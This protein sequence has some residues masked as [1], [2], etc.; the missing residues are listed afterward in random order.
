MKIALFSLS[1]LLIVLTASGYAGSI[2][3]ETSGNLSRGP[4]LRLDYQPDSI[5]SNPVDCFMY[6]VP[7]TSPTAVAVSTEPGT[8]FCASITSWE[9]KQRGS[10]AYV[11]CDFEVIGQGSYCA[12]YVP[13]EM[14]RHSLSR[15]RKAKEITKLL[16]WIRLDGPCLGRIEGYGKVIDGKI[17]MKSVEVSFNR[18]NSQ[19]PVH[20]SIYDIPRVKGKFIYENRINRQIARVNSLGFKCDD[21]GSP[22]MSVEIASLKKAEEKEGFFSCLTAMIANIL[23]TSTPVAPVG[24]TTMMDFGVALYEKEPVFM[25][26][27]ALNI[28]SEL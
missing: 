24:N 8:T 16:E 3:T 10:T 28:E 14:I 1:S 26:P 4:A 21:D 27:A 22:R 7:L 15:K 5:P 18:D 13:D 11:K 20:V 6:F 2:H 23:M 17:Q 19:S 12:T 25:F 9:T